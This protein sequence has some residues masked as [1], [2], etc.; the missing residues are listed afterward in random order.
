MPPA[1]ANL[2]LS[3]LR[4]R[5]AVCRLGPQ[6]ELP[7]WATGS[8]FWSV[9]RTAKGLSV[10]CDEDRVPDGVRCDRGWRAIELRGPFDLSEVGVLLP[11][12]SILARAEVAV[13]PVGTFDTDY[14]LVR[15]EHVLSAGE[16]LEAAGYRLLDGPRS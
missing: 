16:Q 3:V 5:L 12:V 7:R 14:V 8:D 4:A 10:I 9:T 15:E 1:R 6:D 11:I 13:L 2:S